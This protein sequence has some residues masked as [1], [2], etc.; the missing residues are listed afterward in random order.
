MASSAPR[1]IWDDYSL[2]RAV[3]PAHLGALDKVYEGVIKDHRS[4]IETAADLDPVTEDMLVAQTSQL[5]LYQ[6]FVRAH[7]QNTSGALMTEDAE[8]EL[9]A[10]TAAAT[11]D[12]LE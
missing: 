1:F 10:A 5:E 11:G 7:V 3:V 9:A 12:P 2:G 8:T 4:A 6:W